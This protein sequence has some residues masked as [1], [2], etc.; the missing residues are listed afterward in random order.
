MAYSRVTYIGDGSTIIFTVPFEYLK[1]SFVKVVVAEAPIASDAVEWLTATSIKLA[2]TP[3]RGSTIYIYRDTEKDS[4]VTGY[5]NGAVLTGTDLDSQTRQLLHIAQETQD[6]ADEQMRLDSHDRKYDAQN[7]VIK[8]VA[9]PVDDTDAMTF[10]T[11]K[12]SIQPSIDASLA[13]ITVKANQA[14]ASAV[15][16]NSSALLASG[17]ATISGQHARESE[18]SASAAMQSATEAKAAAEEAKATLPANF[19][20]RVEALETSSVQVGGRVTAVELKNTQQDTR[21]TNI[22]TKNTQQDTRLDAV[23]TKNIQQDTRLTAVESGKLSVVSWSSGNNWYRKYSDGWIEQ[24]GIVTNPG[25]G[26]ITVTLNTPMTTATYSV[27]TQGIS[28]QA[29]DYGTDGYLRT[30]G[31]TTTSIQ[32]GGIP[33]AATRPSIAWSVTGF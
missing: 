9:D 3:E 8:N 28:V 24:G 16:A 5:R 23:E 10:R 17:Q 29:A 21:L 27:S 32:I 30:T 11:W 2:V 31:K 4:P 18:T 12:Q 26:L 19:L 6:V 33:A 25:E 22:E 15:S 13:Q 7:R 1:K 20:G 14:E